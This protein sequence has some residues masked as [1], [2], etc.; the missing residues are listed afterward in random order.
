MATSAGRGL[1][2]GLF[3]AATLALAL[4]LAGAQAGPADA[5]AG[6]LKL[7]RIGGFESPVFVGDAPGAPKLLFVVEQRG[8]IRVLRRD[9]T[10]KRDF[11]DLRGR[12]RYGG[13][14]GL[15]S[16]AFDPGYA[17]NRRFYV[18]YVNGNGDL[19]VDAFRRQ[20]RDP[21]R[22]KARSRRKVIEIAHP[23]N[24]NHNGGQLQ[25]GPDDLLYL[26]TGDGGG[27]GDPHANA[28]NPNVLL[29]K[30]LRIEPRNKGGYS[31]PGSNPFVGHDGRD[32]IYALGLRNPYRFSFDARTGEIYI[33]DV[34]Q[35]KWEEI[36]RVGRGALAGSNFGWD[37]F[38]GAHDFEGGPTPPNYRPPVL[39]YSSAGGNCAVTGGYVVR[40][41][42]LKA[43]R[44]RYLYADFC[45]GVLRS[46]NPANPRGS[47]AATGLALDQPS[48]F[49]EGARGRIYVASLGGAV[50]RIVQR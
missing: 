12:V 1:I 30:L 6:A 42:A 3:A 49:G 25:F 32:E 34:G 50:F 26:G 22:A 16:I 31:I 21:T 13:E 48:S 41:R 23:G 2:A 38:E 28:Q 35:D 45:G 4:A 46:F 5:R 29:G 9:K 14:E 39:E 19:E 27:G 15:L 24:S 20:R 40:D 43:L 7:A 37:I 33:G 11:L 47:D 17:R 8:T 10:Q 44:G 36:D 18:Y